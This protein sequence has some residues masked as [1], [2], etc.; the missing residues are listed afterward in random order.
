MVATGPTSST[1]QGAAMITFSCPTCQ[2]KFSVAEHLAGKKVKCPGCG[3]MVTIH[4]LVAI[5]HAEE[6]QSLPPSLGEGHARQ[7]ERTQSSH[8][9]ASDAPT[10]SP[11]SDPAERRPAGHAD[12]RPVSPERD[13]S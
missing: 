8:L 12:K 1:A 10:P 13:A 4:A 2:K 5:A 3:Q 7:D 11:S 6:T 9:D